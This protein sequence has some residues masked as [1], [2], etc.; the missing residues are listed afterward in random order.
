MLNSNKCEILCL[1]KAGNV[2]PLHCYI[3]G[4]TVPVRDE[5]K[6]LGY[7]CRGNLSAMQMVEYNCSNARRNFFAYGGIGSF[8][9]DLS[10]LASRSIINT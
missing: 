9:D 10:P 3:N 2:T 4:S 7:V 1:S 5:V 8:Q 6:C